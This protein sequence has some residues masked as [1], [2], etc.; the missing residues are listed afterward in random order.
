MPSDQKDLSRPDASTPI[1]AFTAV[2][3]PGKQEAAAVFMR[4]HPR[5]PQMEIHP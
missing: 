5:V 3:L 4:H 2:A 1:S